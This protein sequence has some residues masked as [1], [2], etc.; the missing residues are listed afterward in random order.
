[1]SPAPEPAR[2]YSGARRFPQLIGRTPDGARIPGGPYSVHQV[3]AATAL[4]IIAAR[5]LDTW[6]RFG[7]FGNAAVFIG[8]MWLVVWGTGAIPLGARNPLSM[9]AGA[10]SALTAPPVGRIDGRAV[11]L[12]TP[13]RVTHRTT[14]PQQAGATPGANPAPPAPRDEPAP[15]AAPAPARA[16]R[17]PVL[18]GEA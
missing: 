16:A 3:V 1:M 7:L 14:L 13:T 4:L 12:P 10:W 8:A 6:A 15:A 17:R 5:T 18:I 9:A 11:R 2:W